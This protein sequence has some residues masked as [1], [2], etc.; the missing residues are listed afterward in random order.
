MVED[1]VDRHAFGIGA[2]PAPEGHTRINRPG[3]VNIDIAA[4]IHLP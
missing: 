1:L 2:D 3:I 4:R